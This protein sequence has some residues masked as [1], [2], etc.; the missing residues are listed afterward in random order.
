MGS[1]PSQPIKEDVFFYL[2]F[3]RRWSDNWGPLHK[4]KSHPHFTLA[5][6]L[7]ACALA[8]SFR[9]EFVAKYPNTEIGEEVAEALCGLYAEFKKFNVFEIADDNTLD[10]IVSNSKR[11][12]VPSEAQDFILAEVEKADER[13]KN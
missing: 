11:W 4:G 13:E 5:D 10:H 1:L 2:N 8:R 12:E 6:W 7:V 3:A 9:K